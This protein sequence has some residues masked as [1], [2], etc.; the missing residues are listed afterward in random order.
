MNEY[1]VKPASKADIDDL[2]ATLSTQGIPH[3]AALKGSS[4]IVRIGPD[5]DFEV[6]EKKSLFGGKTVK[7]AL[8]YE[9][10]MIKTLIADWIDKCGTEIDDEFFTWHIALSPSVLN[11][12]KNRWRVDLAG[13]EAMP[14]K[15]GQIALVFVFGRNVS[16]ELSSQ[17]AD[18]PHR[19]M[20]SDEFIECADFTVK[21]DDPND[22]IVYSWR[23]DSGSRLFAVVA[24][25]PAMTMLSL[26][27]ISEGA[28][29]SHNIKE[30]TN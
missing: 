6:H 27:V 22:P 11:G 30:L 26:W 7:I 21:G 10:P 8:R 23:S 25:A 12:I 1:T 9:Q 3:A 4:R 17:L 5:N 14:V 24:S 29:A 20:E 19:G 18:I 15:I 2:L 28:P 16:K 13:L